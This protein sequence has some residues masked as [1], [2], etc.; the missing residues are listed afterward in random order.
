MKS[1]VVTKDSQKV[2]KATSSMSAREA[3]LLYI[4]RLDKIGKK[5]NKNGITVEKLRQIAKQQSDN[6]DSS[7]NDRKG[8][9][10]YYHL[11]IP[12]NRKTSPTNRNPSTTA[13]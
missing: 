12:K 8:D 10:R 13:C 3:E 4:Q 7:R 1:A 2:N 5:I 6:W 9:G 11:F